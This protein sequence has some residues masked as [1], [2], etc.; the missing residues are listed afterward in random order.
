M[1]RR[2]FIGTA[3]GA[4]ASAA[5]P[6]GSFAAADRGLELLLELARVVVPDEASGAWT[7]GA[8]RR[9][10]EDAWRALD[11]DTRRS[12]SAALLELDSLAAPEGPAKDFASLPL[13]ER[14]ALVRGLLD[15]PGGFRESFQSLRSM[16]LYAYYD[17][18]VGMRRAGYYPTT[19][20]EGYPEIDKF[21]A[22]RAES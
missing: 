16:I 5:L 10:L 13:A 7:N 14:P 11:Q 18:P 20:F 12:R 22:G 2:S 3:C 15:T 8:P 6:A 9:A 19:Q 4:A 21:P 1:R 17:S